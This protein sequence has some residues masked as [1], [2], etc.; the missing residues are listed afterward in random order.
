[1]KQITFAQAAKVSDIKHVYEVRL[2]KDHRGVASIR[3]EAE[4]DS[5]A[6]LGA[7]RRLFS[8]TFRYHVLLLV[9]LPR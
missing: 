3:H 6:L 9:F 4:D 2:R 5:G 7:A 8:R 1:M